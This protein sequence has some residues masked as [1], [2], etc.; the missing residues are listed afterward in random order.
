MGIDGDNHK[1][2]QKVDTHL[3]EKE[4]YLIKKDFT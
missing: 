4:H 3:A 1:G 2:N